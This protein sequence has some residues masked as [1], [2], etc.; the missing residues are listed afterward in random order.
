MMAGWRSPRGLAPP[1]IPQGLRKPCVQRLGMR[2]G[3]IADRGTCGRRA[4]SLCRF[5]QRR[6]CATFDRTEPS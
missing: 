6:L 2:H 3:L 4:V 5:A 1:A